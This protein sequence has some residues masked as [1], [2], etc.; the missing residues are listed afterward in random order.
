MSWQNRLTEDFADALVATIKHATERESLEEA[1]S[2]A[3]GWH[4]RL[5]EIEAEEVTEAE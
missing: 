2:I 1:V 4:M 3:E 5:E